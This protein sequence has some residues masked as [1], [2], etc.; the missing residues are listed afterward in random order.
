MA[1]VENRSEVV[2]HAHGDSPE[3]VASH[4]VQALLEAM[5][6]A[7]EERDSASVVPMQASG[8]TLDGMLEGLVRDLLEIADSSLTR[9]VDAELSHVMKTGEGLRAWGYVWLGKEGST[10]HFLM[11]K[12]HLDLYA[13]ETGGFE[14]RMTLLVLARPVDLGNEAAEVP[15]Q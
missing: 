8:S 10:N 2:I 14:V 6:T 12:N 9:V 1:D 5:E 11:L 15:G 4:L 3:D 7:A 13:P